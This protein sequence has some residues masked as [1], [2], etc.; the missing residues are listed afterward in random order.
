MRLEHGVD[1]HPVDVVG[2][3]DHDVVRLLVRDEVQGLVDGVGTAL[4]PLLAGALLRGHRGHVAAQHGRHAP[5]LGDVPV[6]RVRLVLGEDGHLREA[7][8]RQVGQDEVDEAVRAAKGNR[9][10]GPVGGEGHQPLALATGQD[11][12]QDVRSIAHEPNLGHLEGKRHRNRRMVTPP[13][14]RRSPHGR[15][16]LFPLPGGHAVTR[17]GHARFDPHPGVPPVH[18]RRRRRP[19]RA[20]RPPVGEVHR[21]GRRPVHGRAPRGCHSPRRELPGR[22]ERRDP[23]A[24]RR[25]GDGRRHP[26]GGRRPRPHLVR[27]VRRHHRRPVPGHPLVVTAHSWSPTAPGRSS[28]SAAATAS[29]AGSRR[30]PTRTRTPS[31]PCRRP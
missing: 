18:L 25:R 12:R 30:P 14:P 3:E 15:S 28:S 6:E 24:R 13:S 31:S 26:R 22:R 8:V 17:S 7:G 20:A 9:R 27:P 19:R 16:R 1:V 10:L 5:R 21:P 4:V 11:N 2:T 23:H 29:Q